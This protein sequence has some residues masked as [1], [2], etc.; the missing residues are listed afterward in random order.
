[1]AVLGSGTTYMDVDP[2]PT[3]QNGADDGWTKGEDEDKQSTA[4]CGLNRDTLMRGFEK[5]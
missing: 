3:R 2:Q 5:A 1:M 4:K